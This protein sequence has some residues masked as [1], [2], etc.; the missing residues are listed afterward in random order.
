MHKS[1]KGSTVVETVV[2]NDRKKR[3]CNKACIKKFYK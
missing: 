2:I 1:S 3:V